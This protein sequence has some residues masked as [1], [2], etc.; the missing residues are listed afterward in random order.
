MGAA[1]R[2]GKILIEAVNQA[3]GAQLTAAI[4]RPDSSLIGAD[5]GELAALGKIGV[6]LVGDLKA[7][8]DQFDV[9]GNL[10]V[11]ETQI[12]RIVEVGQYLRAL[13][14]IV[15]QHHRRRILLALR[16]AP[17][18]FDLRAD[19]LQFG[20]VTFQGAA[21]FQRRGRDQ[22]LDARVFRRG[23][24]PETSTSG[25]KLCFRRSSKAAGFRTGSLDAASSIASAIPSSRRHIAE[26]AGKSASSI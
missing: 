26:I 23:A 20:Q 16:D 13:H 22:R 25:P 10:R 4:D 11:R 5:A 3:Q 18:A 19:L 6:S 2:M 14:E 1:G 15:L 9:R 24:P 7:A 21:C 12:A 8:L 17:D